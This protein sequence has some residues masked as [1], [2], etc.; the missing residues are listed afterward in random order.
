MSQPQAEI[1]SY[2]SITFDLSGQAVD[3]DLESHIR[4]NNVLPDGQKA[5]VGI[6]TRV[7]GITRF[8]SATG[9]ATHH[10]NTT[11]VQL[12]APTG[13]VKVAGF[14]VTPAVA[15]TLAEA[16]PSLTEDPSIK[17]AEAAKASDAA[18]ED[19]AQA[20]D[21]GRHQ[22][23]T[24][25]A[26]HQHLVGEVAPQAI[27]GLMVYGQKGETPPTDL[28]KTIAD[29]MGEPLGTA[30]DK[31]NAVIGGVHRQ[32]TNLA[33]AFGVDPEKA[34]VWLKQHRKDS[35]MAVSQ[36][37]LMRR[38]VRGWLP[39]LEDYQMATGDGRKH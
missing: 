25:E 39:L 36:A 27:I 34:A 32:F 22:D 9:P 14:E 7:G 15:A 31:V 18:R 5:N 26:Y 24:L 20:E 23:D 35:S 6:Q 19:A 2:Q 21:L 29:Q 17:A 38:D 13:L 12:R 37:H 33:T 10:Q 1:M 11:S 3:T 16:A 30:I 4:P 28:L 8:N